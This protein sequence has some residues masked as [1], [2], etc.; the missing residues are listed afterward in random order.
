M[1]N[2]IVGKLLMDH[3][4]KFGE[5]SQN[6]IT[7]YENLTGSLM[8]AGNAIAAKFKAA[9]S[10]LAA[11]PLAT[12][13]GAGVLAA[14]ALGA[15][16]YALNNDAPV[17]PTD[18]PK[19]LFGGVT[20]K[21]PVEPKPMVVTKPMV[22]ETLDPKGEILSPAVPEPQP[23]ELPATTVNKDEFAGE[24]KGLAKVINKIFDTNLKTDTDAAI[25]ARLDSFGFNPD[26]SPK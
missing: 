20:T 8:N 2:Y 15:T 17:T 19:D 9:K 4:E 5:I 1:N 26:G 14:G 23:A 21:T 24:A 3:M 22:V 10:A 11:Q 18:S 16:A 12:K 6:D 7:I 25:R 13:I